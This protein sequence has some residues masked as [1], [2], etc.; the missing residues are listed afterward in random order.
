M[1]YARVGKIALL[2]HRRYA[3]AK[4]FKCANRALKT[5]RTQ[6]G[7]VRRD[8]QRNIKDNADLRAVVAPKLALAE[9]KRRGQA[10]V[11]GAFTFARAACNL[12]RL[13]RL[14]AASA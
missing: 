2:R 8:I 11:N 4:Q 13:P 9:R 1:S 6:L 14:L 5:L 3:H 10:N 7:R 12:V